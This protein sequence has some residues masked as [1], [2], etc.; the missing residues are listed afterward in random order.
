MANISVLDQ[1]RKELSAEYEGDSNN[2][3]YSKGIFSIKDHAELMLNQHKNGKRKGETT[4]IDELD[5]HYSWKRGFLQCF[6]GNPNCGKSEFLLQIS[7]IKAMFSDWKFALF[8]PENMSSEKGILTPDEI[9]DTLIHSLSGQS[10]DPDRGK[11]QIPRD[12]YEHAIDVIDKNFTIIYPPERIKSVPLLMDYFQ[13]VQ[14]K[15]KVDAFMIDPFNKLHHQYNGL[16]DEYLMEKFAEIKD[17]TVKNDIVFSI[18]EHP[19]SQVKNQD[20]SYPMA[21]QYS[22]RGGAAWNNAMDFIGSIHRPNLHTDY[23]DTK[24]EFH[25]LK[26]RNQKLFGMP[27]VIEMDFNRA[28]NRYIFESG[29]PLEKLDKDYA[30]TIKPIATQQS[31]SDNVFKQSTVSDFESQAQPVEEKQEIELSIRECKEF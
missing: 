1:L 5:P 20:G 27:G 19:K 13:H 30:G 6:T 12:A 4:H 18:V 11:Y 15:H 14:D 8:V 3:D 10:T 22:L 9:A 26:V 31:M 7:L 29:N 16:I 25:S 24:V 28:T 23:T 21:N 2:K 17:F